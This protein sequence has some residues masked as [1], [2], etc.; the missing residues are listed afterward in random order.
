[1]LKR[2]RNRH[3][4]LWDALLLSAT[5]FLA[6]A[7]RLESLA[8][9]GAHTHTA[10]VY[11]ALCIPG[12][13]AIF[14]ANGLYSRLWRHA[15]TTD[16][17]RILQATF[18][19]A[20]ACSVLGIFILPA[21]GLTP[22]R[23]PISVVFMD[24]FFTLAIVA[25]PRFAL[26]A[27]DN[28][29]QRRLSEKGKRVLIAG[30]GAAGEVILRELLANPQ[31]GLR[32]VGFVDDDRKK[33]HNRLGDLPIFGSLPEIPAV[34]SNEE[35]DEIIIAMPSALGSAVRKVVQ[36]ANEVG[37]PTR[38]MPGLYE[39]VSGRVSVSSLRKVEIQDLLRREPV[40]TDL[41]AVRGTV[42]DRTVLITGAGGSIGSELTR[43]IAHLQ[44]AR[45]ILLGN[46]ENEIFDIVNEVGKRHP[47]IALTPIIADVRD[48]I[49]L[50]GLFKAVRP[51]VVFH[52][53]A[54][55]H[56]PLM[57]ANVAEAIT[58]NVLGTKNLVNCAVISQVDR[59]VLI[60]TDKAVRPVSIMGASKRAAE[61]VV[62]DAATLHNR[63]FVAVRFGNVL[64]SRGSVVPTFM[65]QIKSGGPVTITHPEMRRYFMTIPEAVQLVL[66]AGAMGSGGE[67][68][69]L[70]MGKPV[71]IVDLAADLIRLSGL[72]IG[73]D[74]QIEYTGTRP[75][76]RLNEEMFRQ[77]EDV[78]ETGHP[79]IRLA[80]NSRL[81]DDF[82]TRVAELMVAA[83]QCLADEELTRL[84][85]LAVPDFTRAA[86]GDG[87]RHWRLKH[88][89]SAAGRHAFTDRRTGRERRGR[90]RRVL[91]LSSSLWNRRE[92]RNGPDRRTG[93]DRRADAHGFGTV[94]PAQLTAPTDATFS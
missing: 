60:S 87:R 81:A 2:I 36:S 38:T 82:D 32:P 26:K 91:G 5:P 78:V 7:I 93:I 21:T 8:W 9:N 16:M 56:V 77:S 13:L 35:I 86:L 89:G 50:R 22:L 48:G 37:V 24:A 47:S 59:L 54:H 69:M 19:S 34:V 44:P 75:G 66:Q 18:G 52:A 94:P 43:Q 49:R 61:M 23:V 55:K 29:K 70:D 72:E 92:R 53:A 80:R 90:E 30:A 71:R 3:L 4:L 85:Q 41:D 31:L 33:H 39:I 17:S 10:L 40:K 20:V 58:N 64:G 15:G 76:E 51:H 42:A 6:Y 74:I 73:T 65:E 62:Q 45:L 11:A 83:Q 12:K 84:L 57:E 79:K 25:F 63:N 88:Q 14:A 1:M 28:W 27:L 68:F 46:A 67:V